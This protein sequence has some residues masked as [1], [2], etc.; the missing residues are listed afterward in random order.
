MLT[1]SLQILAGVLGL[2]LILPSI[3]IALGISRVRGG[4]LS[5]ERRME[6]VALP[7]ALTAEIASVG[8][9]AVGLYWESAPLSPVFI[10]QAFACPP[11]AGFVTAYRLGLNHNVSVAMITCFE[12]GSAVFTQNYVGGL[13]RVADGLIAGP[14]GFPKADSAEEKQA[15]KQPAPGLLT[16]VTLIEITTPLIAAAM[17]YFFLQHTYLVW[18]GPVVSFFVVT[19]LKSRLLGNVTSDQVDCVD[20]DDE[21]ADEEEREEVDISSLQVVLAEHQRR[22]EAFGLAGDR[23]IPHA[24]LEDFLQTQRIYNRHPAVVASF[25]LA[26][27]ET[28][29]GLL[30]LLAAI[31]LGMTW[32]CG[33]FEHPMVWGA[34]SVAAGGLLWMILPHRRPAEAKL[35]RELKGL[36]T[37]STW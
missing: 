30:A 6:E 33:D 8:A 31:G 28:A 16:A 23:P 9:R 35:F 32:L 13:T 5:D 2:C 22:V 11:A 20:E 25:R 36:S 29:W 14:P 17:V 1:L 15:V 26:S 10:E 37:G 3:L 27:L 19:W 7:P 12:S 34:V 4:I 18:V 24:T 21:D